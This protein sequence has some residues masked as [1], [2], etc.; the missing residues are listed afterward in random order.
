MTIDINNKSR[1]ILTDYYEYT[2][3]LLYRIDI[4]VHMIYQLLCLCLFYSNRLWFAN[5]LISP[6]TYCMYLQ[7]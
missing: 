3:Y 5:I 4:E 2:L 6:S 7:N 1:Q